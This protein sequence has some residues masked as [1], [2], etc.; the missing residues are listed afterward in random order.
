MPA[1]TQSGSG[2]SPVEPEFTTEHGAAPDYDGLRDEHR[3]GAGQAVGDGRAQP[4]LML[5]TAMRSLISAVPLHCAR[6]F[7]AI[8]FYGWWG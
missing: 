1:G 8:R 5:I 7:I 3:G 6:R 2:T 4:L